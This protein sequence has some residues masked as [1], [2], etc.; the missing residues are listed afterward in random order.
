MWKKMNTIYHKE[1][2]IQSSSAKKKKF[3]KHIG[4]LNILVTHI[5]NLF[6]DFVLY[7]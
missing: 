5:T 2:Q 7:K 1:N 4:K 3:I 6:K